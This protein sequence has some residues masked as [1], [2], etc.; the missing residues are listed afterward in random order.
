M[1]DQIISFAALGE[2]HEF[3]DHWGFQPWTRPPFSGVLRRQR[4]IKSGLLGRVAEFNALD[5]IVLSGG[6]ERDREELWQSVSPVS[7][8]MTQ[9]YLFVLENPWTE[10]R[11]RSFTLGFRGYL[12]FYAY[13][14]GFEANLKVRDLSGLVDLGLGLL[15]EQQE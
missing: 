12:E 9:R 2:L 6:S 8:V 15:R 3:W 5:C 14:P 4:F 11:I 7:E 10:R 13:W 1:T